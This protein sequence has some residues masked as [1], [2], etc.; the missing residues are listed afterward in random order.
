MCRL[1]GKT[2]LA[3]YDWRSL[4][5]MPGCGRW[6]A[7]RPKW[8]AHSGQQ[9][10]VGHAM[11]HGYWWDYLFGT[12][13]LHVVAVFIPTG[14]PETR[15]GCLGALMRQCPSHNTRGSTVRTGEGMVL[16]CKMVESGQPTRNAQV[17]MYLGSENIAEDEDQLLYGTV[18]YLSSLRTSVGGA[19]SS[20]SLSST[21]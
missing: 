16:Q 3:D 21:T 7:R 17:F 15:G 18:A 11:P 2:S 14:P 10:H 13:T 8:P 1:R 19:S 12:L 9:S 5:G 20:Y 4:G 6:G